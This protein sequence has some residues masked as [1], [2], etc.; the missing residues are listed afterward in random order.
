MVNSE[1]LKVQMISKIVLDNLSS[2]GGLGIIFRNTI[3]TYKSVEGVGEMFSYSLTWLVGA[4]C[5][6]Q[7]SSLPPVSLTPPIFFPPPLIGTAE[8][9]IVLPLADETL[10]DAFSPSP[11][12]NFP[13]PVL[14]ATA[15]VIDS[16]GV[17]WPKSRRESRRSESSAAEVVG[18]RMAFGVER[19]S[20]SSKSGEA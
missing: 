10:P 19:I 5:R 11:V 2:E 15:P 18:G 14:G 13:S 3:L 1:G 7:L 4:G 17:G 16:S 8:I 12:V 9:F 20:G 6:P